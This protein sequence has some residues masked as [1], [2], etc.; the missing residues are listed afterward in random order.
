MLA[1][2][3]KPFHCKFIG[4]LLQKQYVCLLAFTENMPDAMSAIDAAIKEW[5]SKTCI[6]FV[7][8]TTQKDYLWFFRQRG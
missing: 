1:V 3:K 7:K 5:E 2:L 8:R 4:A 6:K